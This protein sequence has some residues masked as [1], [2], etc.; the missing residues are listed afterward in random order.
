MTTTSTTS[1]P[2]S[3]DDWCTQYAP[4]S[5]AQKLS[6]SRLSTWVSPTDTNTALPTPE[7]PPSDPMH[8]NLTYHLSQIS[9]E[10]VQASQP[11]YDTDLAS[12]QTSLQQLDELVAL[13]TQAQTHMGD[14]Q[15]GLTYIDD[16]ASELMTQ[17]TSLL[18]TQAQLTSL[19][20]ALTLRLSYF[21]V[22]AQATQMLSDTSTDVHAPAFRS[23]VH[24]LFLALE[25][26][27]THG[28]YKDAAVYQL[29]LENALQRAMTLIK[30]AFVH[31]GTEH[32]QAART[33]LHE[34]YQKQDTASVVDVT[35]P[36]VRE[37]LYESV[38]AW[39]PMYT[40]YLAPLETWAPRRPAMAT[41]LA[42]FHTVLQ[43]WRTPLVQ[44]GMEYSRARDSDPSVPWVQR[45][46]QA[47][48]SAQR[49]YEAETA[50]YAGL[51][52]D[53]KA[54]QPIAQAVGESV[55]AWLAP[56]LATSP[57]LETLSEVARL[58]SA[59]QETWCAP[60]W[61][62]VQTHL[63]Q[64][65]NAFL[66]SWRAYKPTASDL[67]YPTCAEEAPGLPTPASW[68][69]P[70][71]AMWQLQRWIS[72]CMPPGLLQE[73]LLQAYD[74]CDTKL[75]DAGKQLRENKL[76]GE[77]G[78]AADALLFQ[79][80]HIQ[81][82]LHMW[83]EVNAQCETTS[84]T[85]E[86]STPTRPSRWQAIGRKQAGASEAWRA[87]Q[88]RWQTWQATTQAELS[89]FIASS[90]ALP[91]QIFLRQQEPNASKA[92][93]AYTTFQQSLDVNADEEA[94]KL[95]IYLPTDTVAPVV[96][97]ILVRIRPN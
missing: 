33:R 72:P 2:L 93:A 24:R 16:S 20:E 92:W 21:G 28:Q 75:Q 6:V 82:V 31:Q 60:L 39:L 5:E 90:L 67:A 30:Q 58:V 73:L 51:F 36:A 79:L 81:V 59:C 85:M 49:V 87:T 80:R 68:Y 69:P 70:V 25:F 40:A 12:L 38:Q 32:A 62:S 54:L 34:E 48:A 71:R 45:L 50:L 42:E 3:L 63:Q 29:R 35:A 1:A 64:Q 91:L 53:T 89:T 47:L 55:K 9:D 46:E 84:H 61:L 14:L 95:Y 44:Q 26:M 83:D 78:D 13:V 94:K 65:S 57:S 15:A 7:R 23:I 17:A 43:R 77:E 76:G 22:L 66:K 27:E 37:A 41:M 8:A 52:K 19:H 4:L 96:N 18:H 97:E 11:R 88:Q 56:Q 74:V 86:P 10:L